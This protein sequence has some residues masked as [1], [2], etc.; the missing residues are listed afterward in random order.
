MK[1]KIIVEIRDK[2]Y[3]ILLDLNKASQGKLNL[4]TIIDFQSRAV[5]K[6][7]I[8]Q[9]QQAT[10]IGELEVKNLPHEKA[11]EPIIYLLGEFDG[12]SELSFKVI[13]KGRTYTQTSISI[14][15]IQRKKKE[16]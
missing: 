4:T 14:K 3:P 16:P 15:N 11:G 10:L 8:Y 7:F 1:G 5:I 13:L 2:R 6:I 12:K 9:E